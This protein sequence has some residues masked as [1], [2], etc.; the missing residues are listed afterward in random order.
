MQIPTLRSIS[1]IRRNAKEI[2]DNVRKKDEVVL[3]T[4]NNNQLSVILSP[5]Y[6]QKVLEENE[7]LW[8]ELEMTHSKQKTKKEK[9]YPLREVMSGKV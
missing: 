4:K 6:Y 3:I 1:D 8:E 5:Q 2:F 7:A 9:V